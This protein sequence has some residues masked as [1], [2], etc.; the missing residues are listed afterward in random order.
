LSAGSGTAL[1]KM[2]VTWPRQVVF[3]ASCAIEPGSR[4]KFDGIYASGPSIV[5]ADSVFRGANCE[6]NIRKRLS[7]GAHCLIASN[8][9][10]VDHS[11][12]FNSRAVPIGAQSDGMESVIVLGDDVWIGANVVVLKGATIGHGAIVAAGSVVSKA[13]P[14]FEIWGGVPA[15][16]L[17]DRP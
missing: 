9:Y 6:F 15:R 1:P 14:P 5:F 13:I 3:G 16:K 4:F 8:C 10:F 7:V 12:G 17:L 11:H 2:D